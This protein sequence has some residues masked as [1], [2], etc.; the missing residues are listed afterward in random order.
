MKLRMTDWLVGTILTIAALSSSAQTIHSDPVR[1]LPL[2][3]ITK[4]SNGNNWL[5]SLKATCQVAAGEPAAPLSVHVGGPQTLEHDMDCGTSTQCVVGDITANPYTT[6]TCLVGGGRVSDEVQ[7]I[8]ASLIVDYDGGVAYR[9]KGTGTAVDSGGG[10]ADVPTIIKLVKDDRAGL[11]G[12]SSFT[13]NKGVLTI[14]ID[15]ATYDK[16]RGWR[17][18]APGAH[19]VTLQT[20]TKKLPAGI[21]TGAINATV[22]I[23]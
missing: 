11:S 2:F 1:Y 6:F 18:T 13:L 16:L 14:S 23:P 20:K 8:N 12:E 22:S 3:Q 21:Y 19:T 5:V 9:A 17:V 4:K 15:G 7:T 10:D